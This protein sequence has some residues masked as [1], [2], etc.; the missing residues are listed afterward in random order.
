MCKRS[1]TGRG[2][3]REMCKIRDTGRGGGLIALKRC[4]KEGKEFGKS[5]RNSESL[6]R[7]S[8]IARLY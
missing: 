3:N 1:D 2:E 5:V 4:P 7:K 6:T 8:E